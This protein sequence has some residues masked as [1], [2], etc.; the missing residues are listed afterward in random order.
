MK[1]TEAK[2]NQEISRIH[3]QSSVELSRKFE[4]QDYNLV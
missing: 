1:N 3:I 4:I 2:N